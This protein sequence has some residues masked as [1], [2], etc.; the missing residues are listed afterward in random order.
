MA[1]RNI[2]ETNKRQV[3]VINQEIVLTFNN[4]IMPNPEEWVMLLG[5]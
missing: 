2:K 3:H 5:F 1:D 4:E